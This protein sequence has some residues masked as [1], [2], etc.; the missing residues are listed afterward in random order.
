MLAWCMCA[1]IGVERKDGLGVYK[2]NRTI[3]AQHL[4][5]LVIINNNLWAVAVNVTKASIL[6][7]YLRLF[8]S[9]STRFVCYFLLV[10]LIPVLCWS[11]FAGTFLC[12]PVAK[13]WKPQLPGHCMNARQYWLSAA[14]INIGMDFTV[15][16]LPLPAITQLRLPRKQKICLILIFLLGFLVCVVSVVRITVVDYLEGSGRLVGKFHFH[17]HTCPNSQL[18]SPAESG[19]QAVI[20][21]VVEVNIGMI[22]A[23]LIA[24][25]P[26]L[27][28][29]CPR[30]LNDTSVPS[31]CLRLP[32][33]QTMTDEDATSGFC[34]NTSSPITPLAPCLQAA[35]DKADRH[36]QPAMSQRSGVS[37]ILPPV[38]HIE[39]LG[40]SN[41]VA[42]SRPGL[43]LGRRA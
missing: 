7:Q 42:A 2:G 36:H 25:K 43:G 5:K 32:E 8:S 15:L 37:A 40:V 17:T 35:R 24:L 11:V 34:T 29:F 19:I 1:I 33:M 41:V 22:C 9:R 31:H 28:H 23:S 18:T 26:L 12:T 39:S 3:N 14:A 6:A 16:L 4:A 30:L 10:L 20:W 21:S 27:L 38:L 13:L